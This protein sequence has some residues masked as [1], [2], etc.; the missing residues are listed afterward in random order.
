MQ[1]ASAIYVQ[2]G[3]GQSCP[4]GWINFDASPTLRLQRLPVIG[5]LFKRGATV[6]PDGVR[7]GDIVQGL[8]VP[9]GSVQGIYAS[10]VLEHLSYADF[11][12]RWIILSAC[13]GPVGFS[14]WWFRT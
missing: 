5:R 3:C 1:Q 6:F 7:F 4:D 2:Y 9:D 14:G 10:H 11:W 12:R 13:S 8:P